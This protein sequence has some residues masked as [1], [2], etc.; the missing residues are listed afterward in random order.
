MSNCEDMARELGRVTLFIN[1]TDSHKWGLS[2]LDHAAVWARA[3]GVDTLAMKRADGTNKWYQDIAKEKAL[4]AARGVG[5]VPYLYSYGPRFGERQIAEECA[6]AKEMGDAAGGLVCIDLESEWNSADSVRYSDG[7]S[8]VEV[9]SRQL[10]PWHGRVV[11]STWG[12]PY[13]QDWRG[14]ASGIASVVNAWGPQEYSDWLT[15]Q[16]YQ[17]R[18]LGATCIQPEFDLSSE[19]GTNHVEAEV[20]IA[21]A[22]GHGS[23]WLW[24]Y[25]SAVHNPTLVRAVVALM[26]KATVNEA[27]S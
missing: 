9:F 11:L 12:D 4:C 26:A 24:E 25:E 15:S 8:A 1:Q 3:H 14:V 13:Q 2:E 17:L 23:V 16:E 5:Y 18:T 20:R 19:F 21:V 6:L 10:A 27:T 7:L 22:R